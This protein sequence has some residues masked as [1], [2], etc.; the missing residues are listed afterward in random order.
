MST[1]MSNRLWGLRLRSVRVRGVARR[2]SA[3]PGPPGRRAV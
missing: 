2:A 1:F 3:A